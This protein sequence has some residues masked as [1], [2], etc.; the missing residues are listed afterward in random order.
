[1][2]FDFDGLA[3][4]WVEAIEAALDEVALAPDDRAY[5]VAFWMLYGIEGAEISAPCVALGTELDRE[6]IHRGEPR[7]A[8]FGSWRWN[9]ADW[10]RSMLDRA[11]SPRVV[12]AY[13]ALT[14]A[15][16]GDRDVRPAPRGT[17]VAEAAVWRAHWT[18]STAMLV[19]VAHVLTER[20]RNGAGPFARIARG[21]DFVAVV[22]DP[23]LGPEGVAL[24]EASRSATSAST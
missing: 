15:A 13:D 11:R 14:R 10:P 16:C 1:M 21:P 7:D 9:P 22:C 20:A 2:T 24:F 3:A 17:T 6:A 18:A 4:A 8:G 19:R 5:A 12:A 23:S